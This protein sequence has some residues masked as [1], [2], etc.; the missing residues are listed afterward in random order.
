MTFWCNIDSTVAWQQALNLR[1]RRPRRRGELSFCTVGWSVSTEGV[2]V[3]AF[4]LLSL[5]AVSA[6]QPRRV[7]FNLSMPKRP[8]C[9]R[10]ATESDRFQ[11]PWRCVAHRSCR[12][13]VARA[14]VTF[15][16]HRF[17]IL[18]F[19]V[20]PLTVRPTF[21]PALARCPALIL[22]MSNMIGWRRCSNY[23]QTG[24][25]LFAE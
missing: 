6:T 7:D 16:F 13:S 8:R 22:I 12:C 2:T 3:A 9:R 21:A 11:W 23:R 15:T 25:L 5:S 14:C 17:C 24:V 18:D 20:L 4:C 19:I 10:L 1:R